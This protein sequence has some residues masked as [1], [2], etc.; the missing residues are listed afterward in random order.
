MADPVK[1]T[2]GVPGQFMPPATRT[3]ELARRAEADGFDAMWF[4]C[5]LM[6]WH[7]DSVWTEEFTPIAA[8]QSNPH[9][10]YDPF[11]A[12]AV[13]GAATERLRVGVGVTDVI[14]RHPAMLAQSALTAQ[15][16]A[17]GRAILGL[18]SGETLNV[19]PYGLAFTKPVGR[20]TEAIEVI[21]LLWST[22]DPVTFHGDFFAL[23]DAILGLEP[24]DGVAPPIWLA[25]HGP[26]MLELCGRE[27]DGWLPTKSTPEEYAD[28]LAVIRRSAEGAGRDPDAITSS[29][30]GYVLCAP[31][32]ETLQ[33]MT[34]HPLVRMLCVL[35]PAHVYERHGA[36][37]PF[38]SGSGF[39]GFIP[40]RVDR[41]EAERVI[42]HIPPE[43]VRYATFHGDAAQIADQIRAYTDAGLR[44]LVLWNVTGFAD[45][46]L[47]GYSFKVLREVKELLC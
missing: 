4:P 27:A 40:T 10:Y 28:R 30:L 47:A 8:V 19:E 20:L 34:E 42:A 36:T 44:D 24:L 32:E 46:A 33:R 23:E 39:H 22:T 17:G 43:I 35:L 26:R 29:M 15:H 7:P 31:D 41:A 37:P 11:Q 6:G 2:L 16:Y 25:S 21:K 18:G 14:R 1:L 45:P 13:A 9:M 3:A 12:M 5:H 38:E